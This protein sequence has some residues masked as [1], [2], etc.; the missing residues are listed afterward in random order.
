MKSSSNKRKGS[1]P[2][3]KVA[4][5][6]KAQVA[7]KLIKPLDGTDPANGKRVLV[8]D[9]GGSNVK[10]MLANKPRVKI[11]SRQALTPRRLVAEV[12]AHTRR[13]DYDAISLG[14]PSPVDAD[15]ILEEPNNLSPGW[16]KFNFAKAFG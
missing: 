12:L 11:P 14:F 1:E 8:I 2:S 3:P 7:S 10:V 6:A 15:K 5:N 16:M 4:K 9:I 13:W